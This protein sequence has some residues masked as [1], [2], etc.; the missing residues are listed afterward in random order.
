MIFN[1]VTIQLLHTIL[2]EQAEWE[3]RY[4]IK[5]KAECVNEYL[6]Q[7]STTS[8]DA[9]N[10]FWDDE[11]VYTDCL[12]DSSRHISLCAHTRSELVQWDH[13]SQTDVSECWSKRW[14]VQW[15]CQSLCEKQRQF[16]TVLRVR[17]FITKCSLSSEEKLL[18][19]E[20]HWVLNSELL[21]TELIQYT[22]DSTMTEHSERNVI[23]A[24]LSQQ[25]FWSEML[26]N[27]STFCWNCDKCCTNNSWKD[28]W[29]S[30]LKSLPVS[31]KIWW[32]IFIDFVINLLLSEDCM[33]LLMITDHL[34]KK[35]ILKLC[36]EMTAEWVTQMFVQ[37][38]YQ[39]CH[40]LNSY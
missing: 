13:R 23:S 25:F 34:S 5:M 29:Q 17:V 10:M 2:A 22:Y 31:E 15:A 24:L 32:K 7:Q 37:Q 28:C 4:F 27:V 18:F 40:E 9:D 16:F 6:R 11:Q 14:V 21:C 20:R 38:F 26:Q 33:N 30:F 12:N 3:S 1:T 35:V 19:W 36:K 39:A 8:Y